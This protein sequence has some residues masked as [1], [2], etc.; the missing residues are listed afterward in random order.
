MSRSNL[1]NRGDLR[2]FKPFTQRKGLITAFQRKSH[3]LGHTGV[4]HSRWS[5]EI[6]TK[7]HVTG[8]LYYAAFDKHNIGPVF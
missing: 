8:H 4:S 2:L 6:K 1:I 7:V 3:C 5:S